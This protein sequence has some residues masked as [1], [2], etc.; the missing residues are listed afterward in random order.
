M[1]ITLLYNI[2]HEIACKPGS[3]ERGGE[4]EGEEGEEEAQL[5]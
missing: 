3:R 2:H 5:G 4:R 1:K